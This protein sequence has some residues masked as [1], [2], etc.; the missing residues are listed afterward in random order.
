MSEKNMTKAEVK[1]MYP[2]IKKPTQEQIERAIVTKT[3]YASQQGA[4]G[5]YKRC[6]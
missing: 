5:S 6:L 1:A 3:S 4:F 2:E